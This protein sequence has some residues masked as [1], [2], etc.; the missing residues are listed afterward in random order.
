VVEQV[1][2]MIIVMM[3]TMIMV[4]VVVKLSFL[5][6]LLPSGLYAVEGSRNN[7]V[8]DDFIIMATETK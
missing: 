7:A 1:G 5:P 2:I 8:I 3:M 6:P 4:V